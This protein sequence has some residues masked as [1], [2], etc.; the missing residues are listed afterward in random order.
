VT[1]PLSVS[2]WWATSLPSPDPRLVL[3]ASEQARCARY[4]QADDRAR[5]LVGR[6]LARS[7]AST[8]L[9][10][11]PNDVRLVLRCSV[12]G[13]EDHGKPRIADEHAHGLSLS[14]AHSHERVAVAVARG[15]EVGID[16]ERVAA[17]D[18]LA[19][20]SA[21]VLHD[22]ERTVLAAIEPGARAAALTAYWTRKEAL[23]KATG[24]GLN[25]ELDSLYVTP[26]DLAPALIDGPPSLPPGRV[27]MCELDAGASYKACV[28]AR[29]APQSSAAIAAIRERH[30][31]SEDL[32]ALAVRCSS[33]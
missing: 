8:E 17:I 13:A 30:L 5:F 2:V 6:L 11:A 23:L 29:L 26:P 12:C 7:A 18:D 1:V 19:R 25:V 24:E 31:A 22:R 33:G 10:C 3:N 9:G 15:G 27:W 4:R 16:V 28:A 32:E 21:G 20:Q 14:I